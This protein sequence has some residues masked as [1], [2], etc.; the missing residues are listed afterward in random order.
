MTVLAGQGETTK[1]LIFELSDRKERMQ[2]EGM[3]CAGRHEAKAV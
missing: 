2:A 3:E 1:E